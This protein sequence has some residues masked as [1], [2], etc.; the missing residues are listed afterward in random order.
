[1]Q[2]PF[3]DS[4]LLIQIE[5]IFYNHWTWTYFPL[6]LH[7]ASHVNF[8]DTNSYVEEGGLVHGAPIR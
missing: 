8:A 6:Q 1:M 4:F 2:G 7:I 5:K 3:L